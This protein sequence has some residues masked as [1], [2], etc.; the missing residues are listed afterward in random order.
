VQ[1]GA[2]VLVAAVLV[3]AVLTRNHQ[4]LSSGPG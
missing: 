3:V 4:L 2:T 1:I